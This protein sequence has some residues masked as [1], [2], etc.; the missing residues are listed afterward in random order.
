[1]VVAE[2]EVTAWAAV[3]AD[4]EEEVRALEVLVL[5]SMKVVGQAAPQAAVLVGSAEAEQ[6]SCQAK[7]GRGGAERVLAGQEVRTA[8]LEKVEETQVEL[9][10]AVRVVA[11][12]E[13]RR[14]MVQVALGGREAVEKAV[15]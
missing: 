12:A 15:V 6:A 7:A 4:W 9:K 1:M 10:A 3:A 11:M 13:A 8:E 14:G 5:E 2:A